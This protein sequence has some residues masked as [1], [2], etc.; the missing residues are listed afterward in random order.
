MLDGT[1][2]AGARVV[3][4]ARTVSRRGEVVAERPIGEAVSDAAGGWSLAAIVSPSGRGM[5]LRALFA[6]S[7]GLGAAVS[8]PLD[9]PAPLA[10]SP[11]PAPA[12]APPPSP[13]AAA[14][15]AS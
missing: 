10:I 1:P 8:E 15:P 14:P 12:S 9:L 5:S 4:Q 11:P 7:S 13:P 6:G 2:V 3:L